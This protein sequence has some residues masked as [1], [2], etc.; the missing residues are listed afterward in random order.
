MMIKILC[1]KKN[2]ILNK[3]NSKYL[4]NK[5]NKQ[6]K[7]NFI[8]KIKIIINKTF[9]SNYQDRIKINN[10]FTRIKKRLKNIL[11]KFYRDRVIQNITKKK[12]AIIM[13]T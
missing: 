2:Q 7:N 11:S 6:N 10:K 4:Y 12:K 3:N 1:R 13:R 8:S 9:N 5:N